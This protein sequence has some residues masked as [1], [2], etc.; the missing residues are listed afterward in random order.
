MI[1]K[2][3]TIPLTI[4]ILEALLRRLPKNH[5]KRPLMIE[6]LSRRRSGYLG[7]KSLDFY[8]RSLDSKNN[9]ILHDLNLPDGNYNCQ[10]DTLLLTPKFALIIEVKN[11]TGKLVFDTDNEQFFQVVDGK[12]IG[13]PDPIAQAQRH[14]AYLKNLFPTLE[15]DYLIVFTHPHSILSFTGRNI[16]IREKVCKSSSFLKKVHMLENK[17]QAL[18]PQKELRKI[19]RT[20]MKM[21]TPPTNYILEKYGIKKSEI[22]IGLHCPLCFYLPLIRKNRKWFCPDCQTFFKDAH[23]LSLQDYFLL[24]DTK[25]TNEQ[26]RDFAHFISADIAYKMLTSSNLNH[27]GTKKGRIYFPDSLP[28]MD[29]NQ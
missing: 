27:L 29:N 13:Y 22:S 17:S 6:E 15:I 1:V 24:F 12:E 16:K 7:E 21:N 10:I 3:R 2:K 18:I 5:S 9:L 14:Q 23:L 26:F 19:S 25:I 4:L 28:L 11:M 8:L 20:L